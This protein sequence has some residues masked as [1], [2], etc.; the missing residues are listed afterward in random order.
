MKMRYYK[1]NNICSIKDVLD[2]EKLDEID[3]D[4]KK[5]E[6]AMI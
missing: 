5:Y 2:D 1:N 3:K 4:A 6:K